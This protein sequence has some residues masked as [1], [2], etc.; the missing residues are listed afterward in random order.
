MKE[1]SIFIITILMI[2]ITA[3]PRQSSTFLQNAVNIYI[4][5]D[6]CDMDF[7]REEI[8]FV[9]Y[10]RDRKASDVHIIFSHQKTGGGG[11]EYTIDFIGQGKYQGIDN[12][13]S[14]I[15]EKNDSRDN[16]RIKTVETLKL[17]LVRY[18][19][20]T[21]IAK[22]LFISYKKPQPKQSAK[23]DKWNNWVYSFSLHCWINGEQSSKGYNFWSNISAKRVTKAY[24]IYLSVNG[25]YN[26]SSYNYDDITYENSTQSFGFYGSVVKSIDEHWSSGCWLNLNRSDYG[27]VDFA[28]SL[29]PGIE[30]NIFP[31]AEANKKQFRLQYKFSSGYT[32]YQTETS[33][34]RENDKT[35]RQSLSLET[36]F[37]KKWGSLSGDFTAS[38]YLIINKSVFK[39]LK[40]NRLS[41]N[42]ITSINLWEGL[43]LNFRGNIS[44]IHD[45]I[46]LPAGEVSTEELLLK[47]RELETQYSYWGS[48]GLTYS[49]GS[50]YNNIVNP[51]FGN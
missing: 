34:E 44:R 10:V 45:Q 39:D 2:S 9:N 47:Q 8:Q 29:S 25:S 20:Q 36:G 18:I 5:C 48:I 38:N 3:F 51:R 40:K 7:I 32:D 14:F 1:K 12:E 15:K 11:D 37:V 26:K 22:D 35:L 19:S 27:N 17:G 49:F 33:Y 41:F 30:Y 4:D 31:Y 6:N 24:K 28:V 46:S 13:L 42:G 16:F 23:T 21:S 43:S 50:I